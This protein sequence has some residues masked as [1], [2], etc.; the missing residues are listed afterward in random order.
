MKRKVELLSN[1]LFSKKIM[2]SRIKTLSVSKKEYI[3]GHLIGPLGLIF[4]VNT[5]AALVEK[6]FTQQVGLM[7]GLDNTNMVQLMG[8][9]YGVIMTIAKILAIFVGVLNG[10]LIQHT[11]SKQGRLRPWHL[12]FG[13][14]TLIIGGTIFLFSGDSLGE[15]YWY[16]FFFLLIMYHTVGSVFFYLF[17]DTIVSL[18]SRDSQDKAKLTFIRKVSWTLISGIII[19]MIISMVVLPMWLEHDIS[20]YAVL[21]IALSIISI[22]LLFMEYYYTRERVSEDYS[23]ETKQDKDK[24]IPLKTQLKAL[25]TNK[26]YV[27]FI[28]LLTL[29][30]IVDNF[31]GGNVQY[32]YI[33]FLLGGE[34]DYS[35][36]TIYQVITGI[37]LGLGAIFIYPLSKKFGIRNV[38]I[39][40]FAAV[41]IGSIIGWMFPSNLPIALVAGFLRQL[42]MIPNAY[43]II[44]LLYYSFDSVEHKS[45][46]R[47]E[48][49]LGVAVIV[50]IQAAIWAPFAGG[51]EAGILRRGFV[52][53]VG[54]T[55]SDSVK[56]F[57]VMSF[58]MF[59]LILAASYL[60]LLPFMDVEKHLPEIN[61]TLL[62]R[63][64]LSLLLLSNNCIFRYCSFNKNL[65]NRLAKLILK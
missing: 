47:L 48:G 4:V 62:L 9:R 53:V 28:I 64:K 58:Y 60:I 45:G 59:D 11:N 18:S 29:G 43:I 31:K 56:D 16:Y 54:V 30:G 32:F 26:Y 25:M 15:A 50:A 39:I 42:G 61:S 2:D 7:Y 63:K 6:F 14:V 35:M 52:D 21:L 5:I 19:G 36:Y 17:R 10:W 3:L 40:G 55:A 51:F 12:I 44:A 23:I 49:L 22:P 1:G 57:M 38:S 27:I 33:K 41:F 65:R 20:G 37:P 46:L 8:N 34:T 13:F 24:K